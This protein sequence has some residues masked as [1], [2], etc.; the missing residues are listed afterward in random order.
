MQLW[1]LLIRDRM[2]TSAC[3]RHSKRWLCTSA[4]AGYG[5]SFRLLDMV[6]ES[7]AEHVPIGKLV[8]KVYDRL[9]GTMICE[10]GAGGAQEPRFVPGLSKAQHTAA[11]APLDKALL[12]V[13]AAVSIFT[14]GPPPT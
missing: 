13:A 8:I 2:K 4:T 1:G 6:L 14:L 10:E 3:L 7:A 11:F 9:A 5:S 12:I